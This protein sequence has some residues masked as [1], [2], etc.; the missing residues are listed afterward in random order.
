[1]ESFTL[2][3][4]LLKLVI[5]VNNEK[6]QTAIRDAAL[7][8]LKYGPQTEFLLKKKLKAKGFDLA[9]IEDVI[10]WLIDCEFLSDS[11]YAN[12][13]AL[14]KVRLK[15]MGK[16]RL[17]ALLYQKGITKDLANHAADQALAVYGGEKEV[18]YLYL[19]KKKDLFLKFL[20]EDKLNK[21]FDKLRYQGFN[22]FNFHEIK[23]VLKEYLENN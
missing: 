22:H 15:N 18:M 3:I 16:N 9:E 13:Y 11:Q 5:I 14:E 10:S 8:I 2:S 1:M 6:E 21:V 4:F 19:E 12:A 20:K 7:V 17:I 23:S